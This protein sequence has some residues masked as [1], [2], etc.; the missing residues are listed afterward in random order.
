VAVPIALQ[1]AVKV[2]RSAWPE[3]EYQAERSCP[4]EGGAVVVVVGGA[5]VVVVGGAVE[6][7][8]GGAVVVVVGAV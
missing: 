6:V 3:L 5:V 4:S 1:S 8:V 2:E 7:V